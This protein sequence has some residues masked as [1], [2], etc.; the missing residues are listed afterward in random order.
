MYVWDKDDQLDDLH[1]LELL[2]SCG[3]T[4]RRAI[5]NAGSSCC[6]STSPSRHQADLPASSLVFIADNI[7]IYIT[8]SSPPPPIVDIVNAN[9]I[10]LFFTSDAALITSGKQG[11]NSRNH[12]NNSISIN[13]YIVFVHHNLAARVAV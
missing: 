8:A 4:P 6:S 9:K 12:R 10:F 7:Y 5:Y 2:A 11:F 3:A 1:Q 13:N